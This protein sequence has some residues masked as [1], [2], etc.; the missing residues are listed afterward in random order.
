MQPTGRNGSRA[1]ARLGLSAHRVCRRLRPTAGLPSGDE[2]QGAAPSAKVQRRH[3]ELMVLMKTADDR[4]AKG[5]ASGR[6]AGRL[7]RY[8][9]DEPLETLEVVRVARIERESCGTGCCRDQEIHCSRA[10]RLAS[11]RDFGSVDPPVGAS[12]LSIEGKGI[13]CC[14]RPL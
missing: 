7:D 13:E 12:R 9:I 10:T 5:I 4:L 11:A 6:P 3:Y 14:F 1:L 8:D 2:R